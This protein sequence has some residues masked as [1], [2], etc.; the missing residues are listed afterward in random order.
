MYPIAEFE[1]S[2]KLLGLPVARQAPLTRAQ[3]VVDGCVQRR[4]DI[5]LTHGAPDF[6]VAA[7]IDRWHGQN[8]S[9]LAEQ[10][11]LQGLS[12]VQSDA[13]PDAEN[14]YRER[15]RPQF[16]MTAKRGWTN[17]PNGLLYYDGRYHLFFQHNPYGTD[18]GNMHWGHA[19]S[20]DLV[21]W[22]ELGDALYPDDLGTCFSG[23]GI[24]DWANTSGLG[25]GDDPP[26][27]CVYTSAGEL[28]TQSL[29]YSVDGGDSW[30]PFDGNPVVPHLVGRNRDPKVIWHQPTERWVM[31]L[32]LEAHDYALLTSRDLRSW[33]VIQYL[34]LPGCSECPDL[35][36]LALDGDTDAVHWIFW[37]AN[38][39]Y[40]V[41]Q[42]DGH[43]FTSE[44]A[45]ARLAARGDS[46][47]A[48]TWSDIPAE[49]G[50]RIQ[51]A[52]LRG[53]LPDMPFNQQMTFPQNLMLRSTPRGMRLAAEPV[54]EIGT[55][56]Q[57]TYQWED[58]VVRSGAD[59]L[60][61]VRGRCLD[62]QAEVA[63]G[64]APGFGLQACGVPIVYD[65]VD[66]MLW[67]QGRGVP[68]PDQDGV[69]RLRVLVDR[70][71]VDIYANDGLTVMPMRVLVAER[72]AALRTLVRGEEVSFR[73]LQVDVLQSIW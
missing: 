48:Q 69:V 2:Q 21:H 52:W 22:Q 43:A 53:D 16:H 29:A 38:G 56:T 54:P 1:A 24:V 71:S 26:L 4:F 19:T 65:A 33:R 23:S 36:P 63:L 34:S 70:A 5:R 49:D 13:L 9:L 51:I 64:S 67:C 37:G 28:F 42:F 30:R 57:K 47:A 14:L 45:P 50:R 41:G 59:P 11:G 61:D 68:C 20:T 8:V 15:Y 17:D 31:A 44:R 55:L 10:R 3:I 66:R 32:Y 27:V 58:L 39:T 62:V 60:R 40:L 46:Y 25:N 72:G 6:W 18:W 73:K 35:F 7:D 12:V